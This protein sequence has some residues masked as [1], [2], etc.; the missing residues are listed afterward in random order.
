MG[1]PVSCE[2]DVVPENPG[3]LRFHEALGFES[4]GQQDTEGGEKRV[5]LLVRPGTDRQYRG[6]RYHFRLLPEA[7]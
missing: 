5:R 7:T 3:S 6:R 4:V 2:V 1:R